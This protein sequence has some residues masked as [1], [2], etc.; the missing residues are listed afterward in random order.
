MHTRMTGSECTSPERDLLHSLGVP[1][2]SRQH[3]SNALGRAKDCQGKVLSL[4][5]GLW[6][7]HQ[8]LSGKGI[9][10]G[11]DAYCLAMV[12]LP[13]KRAEHQLT[14]TESSQEVLALFETLVRL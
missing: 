9:R 13:V 5:R 11:F 6:V 4:Q 7:M 2:V 14:L 1:G 12:T 8:R 3:L 10:V